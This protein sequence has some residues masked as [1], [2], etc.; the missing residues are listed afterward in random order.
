MIPL[1]EMK[2]KVGDIFEIMIP[3]CHIG[4]PGDSFYELKVVS[5]DDFINLKF[6]EGIK[7]KFSR[8]NKFIIYHN[9][10]FIEIIDH[11]IIEKGYETV[12]N[13]KIDIKKIS[14]G[15]IRFVNVKDRNFINNMDLA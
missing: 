5:E 3:N 11:V 12:L 6:I 4:R 1:D 9:S 10:I 15:T 13:R 2:S 14:D 7:F 8:N